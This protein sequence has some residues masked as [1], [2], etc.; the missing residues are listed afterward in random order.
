MD[1]PT[2]VAVELLTGVLMTRAIVYDR[3]VLAARDICQ[4]LRRKHRLDADAVHATDFDGSLNAGAKPGLIVT[5]LQMPMF[6]GFELIRR[7]RLDYDM[8]ELPI[9][10]YTAIDDAMA[11][12]KA[13]DLGA[14]QV[15]FR[16]GHDPLARLDVAVESALRKPDLVVADRS[17]GRILRFFMSNRLAP[18]A[19]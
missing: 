6:S 16:G 2:D 14:N 13:R 19:A 3:C 8:S 7:I 11:W 10:A 15:I 18:A 9:V 17:P 1:S 5:E 4:R 12:E